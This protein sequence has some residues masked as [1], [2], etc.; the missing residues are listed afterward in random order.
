MCFNIVTHNSVLLENL[1]N[2]LVK[3]F[4]EKCHYIVV[5]RTPRQPIRMPLN[6]SYNK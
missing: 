1:V 3:S 5:S 6:C 2:R 4:A